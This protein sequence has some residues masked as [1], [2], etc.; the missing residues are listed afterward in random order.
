MPSLKPNARV[1]SSAIGGTRLSYTIEGHPGLGLSVRGDG[2]ASWVLR[3][4][5]GGKQ[6]EHVLHNDARNSDF[7]KIA[8]AKAEWLASVKVHGVDPKAEREAA[9]AEAKIAG[10]T[11]DTLFHE[12]LEK[13][14]KARKKSWP[15]DLRMY[16]RHVGPRIG[17]RVAS[18][19]TRRE[20]IAV[21]DDITK[22]ASGIQANRALSLISV[23]FG[24]ALAVELVAAHPAIRIPKPGVDKVRERV[25]S[26]IELAAIWNALQEIVDRRRDG[27]T[28]QMARLLQVLM[29]TGQR[30]SEVTNMPVAEISGD[31]VWVIPAARMKG[32]RQHTVPLPR[33]AGAIL[34]CAARNG[35]PSG[36]VFPGK[37]GGR[38]EAMSVGHALGRL[39]KDLKLTDVRP[40]DLR[41][42]MAS[43][44]GRLGV[45]EDTIGRVL[46]HAKSGVTAKHYNLHT[47]DPEKLKALRFWSARLIEIA[48]GR[49]PRALRWR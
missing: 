47:Y 6:R 13:R 43:E 46:A 12:W 40:H 25:L 8:V 11:F 22:Q 2:N 41:R 3:Y 10:L 1:I 48:Q 14:A 44:M 33:M 49:K 9:I 34:R 24:W 29:L 21:L 5:V 4:R 31:D 20:I 32:N 26:N 17:D 45:P 36:L 39:M 15:E 28:V 30:K 16:H 42:T 37:N 18:E 27:M 23:V 19:I 35:D 38:L 7:Q